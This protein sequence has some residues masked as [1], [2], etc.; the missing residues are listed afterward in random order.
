MPQIE[1]DEQLWAQVVAF[2]TLNKIA[3]PERYLQKAVW[4]HLDYEKQ[5]QGRYI[6]VVGV[7]LRNQAGEILLVGNEYRQGTLTWTLPGGAVEPGEDYCTAA[8]RELHEETGLQLLALGRLLWTSQVYYGPDKTG[9]IALAFEALEWQGELSQAH[10]VTGGDA[11]LA[12][13]VP[14][15][16][17]LARLIEG[18]AT[19]LHDWLAEP[20]GAARIYWGD[21]RQDEKM[22]LMQA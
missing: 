14:P 13:F 1:I 2:C 22:R 11:R 15:Q 12:E 3:D 20:N 7:L 10:E 19:P 21:V 18:Q 6:P 9:L 16:I 5:A 4:Q 17:A 8:A